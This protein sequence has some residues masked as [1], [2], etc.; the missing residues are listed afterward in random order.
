V[1][2]LKDQVDKA[3]SVI[4]DLKTREAAVRAHAAAIHAARRRAQEKIDTARKESI[5]LGKTIGL[6]QQ[7]YDDLIDSHVDSM[8]SVITE[9]L[10]VIFYDQNNVCL[11]EVTPKRKSIH[12]AFLVKSTTG[13]GVEIIG[14]PLKSFGGGI[15]SVI[16][17]ILRIIILMRFKNLL[18]FIVLDE[19]LV[20]VSD[21][22]VPATAQFIK[23][24]CNKVG[25][26]VL[27]VTHKQRFKEFADTVYVAAQDKSGHLKLRLDA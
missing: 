2:K 24:L 25:M 13:D 9:G 16:D 6:L 26:D 4:V 17:L 10:E 19:S 14:D 22:Y 7:L 12:V 20:A 1:H 21:E 15:A 27:L 11:S 3:L 18:N 5:L 23:E 8:V